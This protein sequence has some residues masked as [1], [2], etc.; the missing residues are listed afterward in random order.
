MTLNTSVDIIRTYS[1]KVIAQKCGYC[2]E[3]DNDKVSKIKGIRCKKIYIYKNRNEGIYVIKIKNIKL[4]RNRLFLYTD[5]HGEKIIKSFDNKI[6]IDV[7]CGKS[8]LLL[9]VFRG[10]DKD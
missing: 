10:C 7:P 5:F 2:L 4:N 1:V 9:K 6:N 3:L 8:N